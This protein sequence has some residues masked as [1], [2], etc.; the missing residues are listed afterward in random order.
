MDVKPLEMI[1]VD[2]KAAFYLS[3]AVIQ[4]CPPWG[5]TQLEPIKP[6]AWEKTAVNLLGPNPTKCYGRL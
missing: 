5:W 3:E 6:H 1:V 4:P 2:M